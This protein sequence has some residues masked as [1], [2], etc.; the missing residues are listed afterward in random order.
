MNKTHYNSIENLILKINEVKI[1]AQS[2]NRLPVFSLP[3]PYPTLDFLLAAFL[4]MQLK[5]LWRV[6]VSFSSIIVI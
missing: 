1:T 5:G 6:A 3:I 2:D 4:P